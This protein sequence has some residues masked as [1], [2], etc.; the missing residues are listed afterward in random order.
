MTLLLKTVIKPRSPGRCD[1][2]EG[3]Q[4]TRIIVF[5]DMG[6]GKSMLGPA[7]GSYQVFLGRLPQLSLP[8]SSQQKDGLTVLFPS[9]NYLRAK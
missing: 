1:K 9:W 6:S 3:C 5:K 8:Q 7:L 4:A 2:R